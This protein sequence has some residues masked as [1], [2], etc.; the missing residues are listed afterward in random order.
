MKFA[1]L[2]AG[3]VEPGP[4]GQARTHQGVM[5]ACVGDYLVFKGSLTHVVA[6]GRFDRNWKLPPETAAKIAAT[7]TVKVQ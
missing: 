5:L 7:G 6:E 3:I 4:P 1:D 2:A